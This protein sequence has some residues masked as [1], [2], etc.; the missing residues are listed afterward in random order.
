MCTD[1]RCCYTVQCGLHFVLITLGQK[2]AD[3]EECTRKNDVDIAPRPDLT[4]DLFCLVWF[5]ALRIGLVSHEH[6][7]PCELLLALRG[8]V[9]L[10]SVMVRFRSSIIQFDLACP[11]MF[12]EFLKPGSIQNHWQNVSKTYR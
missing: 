8:F 11:R 12:E 10:V 4:F 2:S 6:S 3:K 7:G 1:V 5:D 9:E